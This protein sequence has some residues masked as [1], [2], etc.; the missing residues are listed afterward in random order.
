MNRIGGKAEVDGAWG[1]GPPAARLA[2]DTAVEL[3]SQNAVSAVTI[4]RCNHIGRLG[5]Y[6]ERISA[7]GLIGL[8]MCN[9]EPVVAPFGGRTRLLGTNPIAFAAPRSASEPPLMIDFATA[10]VA[11]GKLRVAR[12][13]GEMIPTGLIINSEGRPSSDP[14]DFYSGGALLPFGGHKGYGLSMMA[15]VLVG[16]L[17]GTGASCSPEYRGGNGTIVVALD[18]SS[19][20]PLSAFVAQSHALSSTIKG[21]APVDG[22]REVLL[23]GEPEAMARG[24][25]QR[26]GISLP[27]Q[28]WNALTG[29]AK[30]LNARVEE[31]AS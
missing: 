21:S 13:S 17:S 23:P 28:T 26:D 5:E 31:P 12:D 16:V 14:R 19:F 20:L 10:T 4:R 15:E 11:E 7:S 29:L 2:V 18:I 3:A 1:W 22:G 9:A 24:A 25:R 8:A 30:E 6:V 27:A